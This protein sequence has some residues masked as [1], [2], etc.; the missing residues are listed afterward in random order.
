[1][2]RR[3]SFG[4]RSSS[5]PRS[6]KRQGRSGRRES[7][8]G[9]PSRACAGRGAAAAARGGG[10]NAPTKIAADR[11]RERFLP[12]LR[13]LMPDCPED[14]VELRC[15][16]LLMRQRATNWL[17]T[18]AGEA[19]DALLCA[20]R[21]ATAWISRPM[22]TAD[23]KRAR[24]AVLALLRTAADINAIHSDIAGEPDADG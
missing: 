8:G 18:G 21:A 6:S 15:S 19:M 10:V 20:D 24:S 4:P 9:E 5:S 3:Q 17:R 2:M 23:L 7:R 13:A 11:E 16:L 12:V 1:M 22:A 14:Q